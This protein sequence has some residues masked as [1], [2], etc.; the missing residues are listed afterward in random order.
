MVV[1]SPG[2][3]PE[4]NGHQKG[5]RCESSTVPAAVSSDNAGRRMPLP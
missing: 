3:K 5:M 4:S 1:H 2:E